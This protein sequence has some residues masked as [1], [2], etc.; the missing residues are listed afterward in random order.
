MARTRKVLRTF[1]DATRRD[2][3]LEEETSDLE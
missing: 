3:W 1:F 2:K